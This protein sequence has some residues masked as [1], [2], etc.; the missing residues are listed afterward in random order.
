MSERPSSPA[1]ASELHLLVHPGYIDPGP[2]QDFLFDRYEAFA[3]M[4]P[5]RALLMAFAHFGLDLFPD[6]HRHAYE[7][8]L[9]MQDLLRDRMVILLGGGN[10]AIDS[11][12]HYA[13]VLDRARDRAEE[14]GWT[15]SHDVPNFAWGETLTSCVPL[16]AQNANAH[17]NLAQP[18]MVLPHLTNQA[19]GQEQLRDCLARHRRRLAERY[20]RVVFPQWE[21]T[22]ML[23]AQM[24][25]LLPKRF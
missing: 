13:P 19:E 20:D 4:L 5:P 15:F 7:R 17:W 2:L 8:L 21:T 1:E 3:S 18:T 9:A 16:S 10:I 12:R 6:Q 14:Q 24:R 23:D 11:E 25:A 22:R